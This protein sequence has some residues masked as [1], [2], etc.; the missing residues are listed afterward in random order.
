MQVKVIIGTLAFMLAMIILGLATLLEPDRLEEATAAYLGR[1]IENGA[2]LFRDS[3]VECHG[4]EGMALN[5]V[6][7]A[8]EEKGCVGLP[9]NHAPLLC[10]DSSDRM[11]QHA[12]TG[13]KRNFIRQTIASGRPNTLMPTWSSEFGGSLE[14]HELDQLTEFIMNW[15]EELCKD[16]VVTEGTDWPADWGDLPAGDAANG[17][18]GYLAQGCSGCHGIPESSPDNHLGV[19]PHLG[20]IA[21]AAA[22]R[23]PGKSAEQYIYE[24][25]LDPNKFIVEECPLG[26]CNEPSQMRLDFGTVLNEQAMADLIAYYMTLTGE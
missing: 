17:S 18:D 12:Y 25:I 21:N 24:S 11:A 7:S 3:C 16:D 1:Q 22:E 2:Q 6:D 20:N 4:T 10:G 9:L 5:C 14:P 15:G 19:G 26:P 13:S 8:G 23:E